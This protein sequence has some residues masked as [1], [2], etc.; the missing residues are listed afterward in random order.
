MHPKKIGLLEGFRPY[1]RVLL[2]EIGVVLAIAGHP[3]ALPRIPITFI[4][5]TS[6]KILPGNA[7]TGP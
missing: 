1:V 3:L 5:E 6:C 7:F 2:T 4:T